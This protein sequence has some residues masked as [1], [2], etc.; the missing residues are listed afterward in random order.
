LSF[1]KS[2]VANYVGQGFT[3][4]A[5]VLF[6]PLYIKYLGVEAYGL[7][8]VFLALQAWLLVLDLGMTPMLSREMAL[9]GGRVQTARGIRDLMRSVATIYL[10]QIAVLVGGACV[11][12]PWLAT[13]WFSLDKLPPDTVATAL[14]VMVVV[15]ALRTFGGLYRGALQ[16]LQQQV[17][18]N[19]CLIVFALIRFGGVVPVLIWI[20]PTITAFFF[21]Q[22]AISLVECAVL[23]IKVHVLLPEPEYRA[24]FSVQSIR[25]VWRFTAGTMATSILALTLTQLD[26]LLL[27]RMLELEEFGRYA[28]A[29]TIA[30]A[31]SLFFSPVSAAIYPRFTALLAQGLVAELARAYHQAAQLVTVLTA[32][33]VLLLAVWGEQVVGVWTGDP[34]LAKSVGPVLSVLAV[35]TMLNGFMNVPYM[36]QL[37]SGWSSFAAR[38]NFVA[39]IIMVPTIVGLIS[40]FGMIGAAYAWILL[41]AGYIVFAIP[42]MHR[43]LLADEKWFWYLRDLLLPVLGA[44]SALLVAGPFFPI[45]GSRFSILVFLIV[46]LTFSYMLAY[47]AAKA[48]HT[49][50]LRMLFRQLWLR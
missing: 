24:R 35:G 33:L 9:S 37:A 6:V 25:G 14:V 44:G 5:G 30:G 43:R 12:A 47:L 46:A 40:R 32:P 8:G 29:S 36:L 16:G 3:G 28:L 49:R 18:L 19:G 27:T 2:V 39:L 22:L 48:L 13:H 11:V 23:H 21:W 45:G 7:I 1:K 20:S 31:L 38:M 41:N 42:L 34:Q 50:S 15:A 26:K 17:W 4:L 10:V